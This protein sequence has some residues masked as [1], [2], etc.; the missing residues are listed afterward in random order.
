[1]GS[2]DQTTLVGLVLMF[3]LVGIVSAIVFSLLVRRASK[4]TEQMPPV[5]GL[6]QEG[7]IA[8]LKDQNR[9]IA[10]TSA[11][12]LVVLTVAV[13]VVPT[14]RIIA[15][16]L[17]VLVA[18]SGL[19]SL[20]GVVVAVL[21]GSYSLRA[22]LNGTVGTVSVARKSYAAALQMAHRT[23]AI[24]SL[25]AVGVGML[26]VSLC[27]FLLGDYGFLLVMA[28]AP[29]AVLVALFLRVGGG[30]YARATNRQTVGSSK[31][32]NDQGEQETSSPALVADMV[33]ESVS[34]GA[35]TTT[36]MFG[37]FL[38]IMGSALYLGRMMSQAAANFP[39][40]QFTDM[41]Y[42][43]YPLVLGGIGVLAS[44]VGHMVVRTS[45]QQRHARAA[46]SR[47]FLLTAALSA[48]GAVVATLLV[49]KDPSSGQ[50]DWRPFV[51]VFVGLA[52]AVA[53][54]RVASVF[55]PIYFNPHKQ[56]D[57]AAPIAR[58]MMGRDSSAWGVLVII[59]A[60]VVAVPLFVGHA[61]IS[62]IAVF[63]GVSLVGVGM[64]MLAGYTAA[65]DSFGAV[66]SGAYR[67]GAQT[68]LDKNTR[69]TLE[70]LSETGRMVKGVARGTLVGLAALAAVGVAGTLVG[71]AEEPRIYAATPAADAGMHILDPSLFVGLLFGL[72][73]PI[74][75][76]RL[77][78]R[79]VRDI[80]LHLAG[81]TQQQGDAD[82]GKQGASADAVQVVRVAAATARTP[83]FIMALVAFILPVLA[84][85]VAPTEA[86]V[87]LVAG[88]AG[89]SLLLVM[90]QPARDKSIPSL[91]SSVIFLGLV[92]FVLAGLV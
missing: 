73:L 88:S 53:L 21:V 67:S 58:L 78:N 40:S 6:V 9:A 39:E 17:I 60:V 48:V 68:D 42:M 20:V 41:R 46:L 63:Y 50:I 37:V 76:W 54:D 79:A 70:D 57:Y 2:L 11:A 83:V 15:Q 43:L 51:A 44:L 23:G 84:V 74:V 62:V 38:A 12:L 25:L 81:S 92:A 52:L 19:V 29:G 26:C 90:F 47:G 56:V 86:L 10:A 65:L 18:G 16:K 61:T 28:F 64:L 32:K 71:V 8:Y 24:N 4:S 59:A 31:P 82:G 14:W 80:G 87:G 85:A 33:G 34:D 69:N 91:L 22:V 13:L 7:V 5:W 30:I 36:D 77:A 72:V 55:V 66:V 35:G 89:I 27:I 3:S 49:L 75:V 45:D 1:M